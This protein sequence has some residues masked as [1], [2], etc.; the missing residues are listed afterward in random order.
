MEERSFLNEQENIYWNSTLKNKKWY[1]K[2]FGGQWRLLKFGR[3]TP[4]I[5]MFC[6]WTKMP[7][8]CW[9]GYFEVYETENYP[10]TNVDTK[11]KLF[12]QLFK[13]LFNV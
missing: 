7:N 12:K 3:D 13:Q 5:M 9:A 8:D 4:S 10:I 11:Y 1:R 2:L 6:T